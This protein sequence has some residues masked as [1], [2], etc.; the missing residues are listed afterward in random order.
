MNNLNNQDPNRHIPS[1]AETGSVDKFAKQFRVRHGT[2]SDAEGENI[3]I[4]ARNADKFMRQHLIPSLE[5]GMIIIYNLKGEPYTRAKRWRDTMDIDPE[6]VNADHWCEQDFQPASPYMHFQPMQLAQEQILQRDAGIDVNG[7]PDPTDPGHPGQ[8]GLPYIAMRPPVPAVR[9]Q[10]AVTADRCLKAYLLHTFQKRIDINAAEKFLATF[11]T[12]QAKQTCTDFLDVFMI[13][14]E[15]YTTIRWTAANREAPNFRHN[16][17]AIR[18][19]YI[20][21]GLCREFKITWTPT[22][23]SSLNNK[24]TTKHNDGQGKQSMEESSQK[25]ARNQKQATQHLAWLWTPKSPKTK[26]TKKLR[27]IHQ[28]P[29]EIAVEATLTE[30]EVVE[31]EE[32]KYQTILEGLLLKIQVQAAQRSNRNLR[33]PKTYIISCQQKTVLCYSTIGDTLCVI[34]AA[35]QAT[36][37]SNAGSGSGTWTTASNGISTP[38]EE[39]YHLA[40]N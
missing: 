18:L 5:M 31:H 25:T 16:A 4:F 15:Y 22:P 37:D 11:R 21:D 39:T 1:A 23:T 7:Q 30:D 17:N 33:T 35:Y 27:S 10:V 32:E 14:F 19:Q 24:Q 36:K 29:L 3:V 40:T 13:K 9:E 6:R 8:V 38:P 20:R 28:Q 12:Q 2:F 26:R 34:T